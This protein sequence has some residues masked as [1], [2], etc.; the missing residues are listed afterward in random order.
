MSERTPIIAGNWK[1]FKT[2]DES[3][4]MVKNLKELVKDVTETEI[5]VCPPFVSIS[6]VVNALQDSN[7]SV[8]AQNCHWEDKGAFTG[9]IAPPMLAAAGCTYVIIGHSERRKY[10][11][12]TNE[13]VNR[14]A[15]ALYEH[16]LIPIIC[17]GET[18]DQREDNKTM[19]VVE[20]QIRGCLADI[21]VD[22]MLSTVIAYEPVWAIG[23]GKTA[24]PEQAQEVHAFIRNLLNELYGKDNAQQIRIQYGG[25]VKP[26]NIA[27]L[28]EMDD[29]DGALVGGASLEAESFA[30][31]I[32]FKK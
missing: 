25:S 29:I 9:E 17:V 14:K 15:K 4:D 16:S 28:M 22:K 20:E 21:P 30:K 2:I 26:D 7:I 10:F 8:G 5:V 19:D 12:E 31:I 13:H 1:M 3:V 27:S 6:P 18:L 24:S 11:H 23:T 32:K